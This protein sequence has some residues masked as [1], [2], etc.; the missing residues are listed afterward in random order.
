[1]THVHLCHG[2]GDHRLGF[3]YQRALGRLVGNTDYRRRLRLELADPIAQ[4]VGVVVAH[5]RA[6]RLE[7]DGLILFDCGTYHPRLGGVFTHPRFQAARVVDLLRAPGLAEL[8]GARPF[9]LGSHHALTVRSVDQL[10]RLVLLDGGPDDAGRGLSGR[11]RRQGDRWLDVGD[12]RGLRRSAHLGIGLGRS[13]YLGSGLE[14]QALEYLYLA[15]CR[16]RARVRRGRRGGLARFPDPDRIRW[17]HGVGRRG[18]HGD[19]THALVL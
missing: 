19:G 7:L 14:R 2:L 18:G 13:A 12:D 9:H 5:C 17:N 6:G 10:H 15:R 1:M 16:R 4:L 3:G 11:G 8:D